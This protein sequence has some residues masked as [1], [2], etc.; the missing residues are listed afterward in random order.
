MRTN[1][2]LRSY[3]GCMRVLLTQVGEFNLQKLSDGNRNTDMSGCSLLSCLLNVVTIVIFSA[4]SH[5]HVH[6]F[7]DVKGSVN[8]F[9]RCLCVR[10]SALPQIDCL[11][12]HSGLIA[13][14]YKIGIQLFGGCYGPVN[15]TW[16]PKDKDLPKA[17]LAF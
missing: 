15:A 7:K 16:L 11:R 14:N 13:I 1:E 17:V 8:Y 12:I 5:L 9:C 10:T 3:V 6:F 4:R 2:R